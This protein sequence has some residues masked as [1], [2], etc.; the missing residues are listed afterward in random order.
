MKTS[1]QFDLPDGKFWKDYEVL[2]K[3]AEVRS[4]FQS[5]DYLRHLVNHFQGNIAILSFNTE[6]KMLGAIF[7]RIQKR[8]Y[9]FLTD[10]KSDHNFFIFHHSTPLIEKRAILKEFLAIVKKKKWHVILNNLP[11]WA[12]YMGIFREEIQA[13][14]LFWANF[15][16]TVCKVLETDT[17]EDLYQR[18][19]QSKELRYRMNRLI[20]QQTAA[21]E[22][23]VGSENLEEWTNDFCRMH[24]KRWQDTATP[25]KYEEARNCNIL[26]TSM[27]AWISSGVLAR[28]SVKV[29][30]KRIA[31]VICLL[32]G[33]TLIHHSTAYDM[34]FSKYS[35]GKALLLFISEWMAK[36]GLTRLD[37]GEGGEV[38][39]DEFANKELTL[40]RIFLAR[41]YNLS[42]ILK[43]LLKNE[44][45]RK[46][47]T[48]NFFKKVKT[49]RNLILKRYNNL[50]F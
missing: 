37:F 17:P 8:T 5:P 24:V 32:Q 36:N 35:P 26:K 3:N 31:Y 39:K 44:L 7:L 25:S 29:G 11:S 15:N 4:P 10:I 38:Y 50:L 23:L 40:S 12:S 49:L 6:E 16:H 18:F 9:Y 43:I 45:R 47:R 34:E 13:S 42:F 20:N 30:E 41:K 28:F 2:W 27:A 48:S 1:V 33:I 21:F 19:H 22:V 46:F 14:G